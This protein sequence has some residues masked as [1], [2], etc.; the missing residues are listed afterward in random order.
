V[1]FEDGVA[2]NDP[3]KISGKFNRFLIGSI[4]EIV[5]GVSQQTFIQGYSREG[6]F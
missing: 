5:N 1:V 4:E 2:Y 6:Y 3:A